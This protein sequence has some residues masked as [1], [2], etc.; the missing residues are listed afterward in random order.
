VSVDSRSSP[1]IPIAIPEGWEVE[2]TKKVGP[3]VTRAVLRRPDGEQVEWSSRR[4][5]KGL[6]LRGIAHDGLHRPYLFRGASPMSWAI[7]S[8]FMIGSFC[9]ALGSF[10]P[11]FESAAPA[12]VAW[13]FFVGS[14]FFTSAAY[15]QLHEVL[16][17]P[18]GPDDK[19]L[20]PI[21]RRFFHVAARR[22]DWWATSV[23]FVGTL[24]FNVTTFAATR[25]DL[26]TDQARRLIWAPDVFGSI[27]FLI[28]SWLAYLETRG[29]RHGPEPTAWWINWLN[30]A[31]SVA[32]GVSAVASRYLHTTGEIANIRL[33]NLG[34]FLGAVGFFLGA[35]LL[36]VESARDAAAEASAPAGSN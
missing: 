2:Q 25:A 6:G 28:A 13:T 15:L 26:S 23:Q 11:Y 35:L 21:H 24:F 20:P 9:F 7:G 27:C 29:G 14:I 32:F 31:G 16:S 18:L 34:T 19:M 3:F 4:H 10:P 36:P 5:R 22:I 17:A 8:L 33:V 12:T 30:L 1:H